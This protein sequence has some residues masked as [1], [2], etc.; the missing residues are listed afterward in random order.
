MDGR[1]ILQIVPSIND[2][3]LR[4]KNLEDRLRPIANRPVDITKPGWSLNLK[5]RLHPLDEAGVR[6]EAESLLNE[7]IACY[8]TESEQGRQAIRKLF[9]ENRA[10]AWAASLPFEPTTPE[11]FRQ[12]L[13]LFS[14]KDQE[15][16]S[17]DA[18]L[19][20]QYL[21]RTA[22]YAGVN[23]ADILRE[24]AALSSD[25]NKYG[26]GSTRQMLLGAAAWG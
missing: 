15:R 23:T 4:I 19:W 10:L 3:S 18:V 14:I 26:M 9:E 12:H 8:T 5:D 11:N 22:R 13:L 20:L 21:C 1:A 2:F 7:V 24:V 17:R 6:S 16:D 25:E